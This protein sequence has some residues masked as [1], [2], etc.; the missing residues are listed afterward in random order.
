[1]SE[2]IDNKFQNIEDRLNALR[3][4]ILELNDDT[5]RNNLINTVDTIS[6]FVAELGIFTDGYLTALKEAKK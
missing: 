2:I 4:K 6:E 5:I 1:M 3:A